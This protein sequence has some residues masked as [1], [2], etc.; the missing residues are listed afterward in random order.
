M[1]SFGVWGYCLRPSCAVRSAPGNLSDELRWATCGFS[2]IARLRG[3][4]DLPE[5][6]GPVPVEI[7][8]LDNQMLVRYY[9]AEWK[10]WN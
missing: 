5:D 1:P 2:T 3:L 6:A 7:N 10:N 8:R 4:F 9:E